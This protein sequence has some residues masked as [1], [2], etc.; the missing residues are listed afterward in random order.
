MMDEWF[1]LIN[2]AAAGKRAAKQWPFISKLLNEAGIRFQH[3]FSTS[4]E[5]AVEQ[6][7]TAVRQGYRHL[8]A[9][10][11]DGT[12]NLVINGIFQQA[13]VDTRDIVLAIIPVGTGNDWIRTH[14]IP[15]STKAAVALLSAHKTA[16]HDVGKITFTGQHSTVKYF[17][18]MAGFGFQGLV[19]ERIEGVSSGIKKGIFAF[20]LGIFDALFRYQV[21]QVSIELDDFRMNGMIYNMN[22][23][24]CK[25]CGGGMKMAP[26]AVADDGMF[27]ITIVRKISKGEVIIN[28]P[29]LFSGKF[30]KHKKVSSHRIRKVKIKSNP[31]LPVECDGEVL[32]YGDVQLQIVEKGIR[33]IVP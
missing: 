8:V 21:T 31:L 18:N 24:I 26:D 25:F 9:V 32:G 33:V 19:A 30:L 1:I 20:V 13:F 23:G 3:R 28:I 12:L 11:G 7:T 6:V 2:P 27:D 15:R 16:L 14:Q 4:A 5:D 29:G 17:I 22:A 10:G